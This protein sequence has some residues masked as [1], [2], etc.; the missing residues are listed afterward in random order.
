MHDFSF[1]LDLI[2]NLKITIDDF[3]IKN[4]FS[5]TFIEIFDIFSSQASSIILD[6]SI[7]FA[8]TMSNIA[9]TLPNILLNC[10]LTILSSFLTSFEYDF[11]QELLNRNRLKVVRDIK[12]CILTTLK[13][14]VM[15]Y[16]IVL[17][18]TFAGLALG[19][20]I[21]KVDRFLS[22]A[23]FISLF[24]ILPAVGIGFFIVPWAIYEFIVGNSLKTVNLI[25]IYTMCIIIRNIV[26]PKLLSTQIGVSPLLT[27]ICMFLGAKI[28]GFIGAILAPFI[29]IIYKQMKLIG[30]FSEEKVL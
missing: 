4:G 11:L 18:I 7:Y 29:L 13:T 1:Y 6:M 20:Y 19:F 12:N 24:D 9:K 27:I 22:I 8:K 25:V 5:N 28:F 15:S 30:Y 23:F 17:C 16:F 2:S 21:I 14:F 10:I 3:L 26:E